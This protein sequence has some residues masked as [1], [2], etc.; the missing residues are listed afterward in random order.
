MI[1]KMAYIGQFTGSPYLPCKFYQ[2]GKCKKG[3][4]CTFLHE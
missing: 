3:K 4:D 2:E 1:A